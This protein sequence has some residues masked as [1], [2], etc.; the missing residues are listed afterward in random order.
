MSQQLAPMKK[1][2]DGLTAMKPQL[3]E[4]LPPHIDVKKFIRA[5]SSVIQLNPELVGDNVDRKSLFMSCQRAATDGLVIDSREAALVMFNKKAGNKW[6]KQVQYMPMVAGILKKA[7]NSGE[8]GSINAYAVYA[9]DQFEYELGLEPK[10]K[11]VPDLEEPGE[12]RLAYAVAK[13]KD[14]SIQLQVMSK[15]KIEEVRKVSKSGSDDQ[16]NA[17]GI[18]LKWYDEMAIKTVLRRLCKYLPSST[19]LDSV[20]EASDEQFS[21]RKEADIE[22]APQPEKKQKTQTKAESAI[23]GDD[24]QEP[25]EGELEE[26]DDP[27]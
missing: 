7:R 13:L 2:I 21:I 17:K 23:L 18:W 22:P 14:G 5:A 3:A 19:D 25:I 10:I 24:E 15:A 20:I 6:I 1:A 12:F 16:G 11:H 9:N 8:I 4:V 27:I 26:N